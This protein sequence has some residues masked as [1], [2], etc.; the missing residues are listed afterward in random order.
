[1]WCP[2]RGDTLRRSRICIP[3]GAWIMDHR[4]INLPSLLVP[5]SMGHRISSATGRWPQGSAGAVWS[6]CY[7][8][9]AHEGICWNSAQSVLATVLE[10]RRRIGRI[11]LRRYRSAAGRLCTSRKAVTV[12]LT[13]VTIGNF[14]NRRYLKNWA[15]S[16]RR[17]LPSRL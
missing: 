16:R 13:P 3:P 5:W 11:P 12:S 6:C 4:T 2:A 1:V 15:G 9:G 7:S 10:G 8:S 14:K 17:Y